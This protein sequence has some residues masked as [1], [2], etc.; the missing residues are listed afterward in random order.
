MSQPKFN[1]RCKRMTLGFS[2]VSRKILKGKYRSI[3]VNGNIYYMDEHDRIF[4]RM[5]NENHLTLFL[6]A[7]DGSNKS[8]N[9]VYNFKYKCNQDVV[10]ADVVFM[11]DYDVNRMPVISKNRSVNYAKDEVLAQYEIVSFGM[12]VAA[13]GS[14]TVSIPTLGVTDVCMEVI[15]V[16]I[17]EHTFFLLT[18]RKVHTI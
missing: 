3:V 7:P 14:L 17:P 1:R 2:R 8:L 12:V 5:Q 10:I 15:N 13:P 9:L 16:S 11:S 4:A 6:T 18:T